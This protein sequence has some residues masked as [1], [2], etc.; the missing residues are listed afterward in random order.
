MTQK[1]GS[2]LSS[3]YKET[4]KTYTK[5]KAVTG[6]RG[7]DK[8]IVDYFFFGGQKRVFQANYLTGVAQEIPD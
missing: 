2:I 8:K 6:R 7:P 1:L 4:P 3:R 5:W